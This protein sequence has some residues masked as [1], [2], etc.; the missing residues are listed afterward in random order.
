MGSEL[1]LSLANPGRARH[2][3]S[4]SKSSQRNPPIPSSTNSHLP[5]PQ[6]SERNC[7]LVYVAPDVRL[8]GH[9]RS[10]VTR[11]LHARVISGS[12]AFC[13]VDHHSTSSLV[14]SSIYIYSS[15]HEKW[16][17][18]PRTLT[19]SNGRKHPRTGCLVCVCLCVCRQNTKHNTT[20]HTQFSLC[21]SG[22]SEHIH[23][24]THS[25]RVVFC[26]AGGH[27][28]HLLAC[29]PSLWRYIGSIRTPNC[30]C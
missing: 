11:A 20:Q 3:R 2:S 28:L 21:P 13:A 17:S 5:E 4:N 9:N 8:C 22:S 19:Q 25:T 23:T 14:Y 15:I 26:L 29:S 24:Q 12:R 27:A 6:P 10:Q 30:P 7:N 18:V 1:P 16:F